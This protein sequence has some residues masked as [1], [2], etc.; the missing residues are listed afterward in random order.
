MRSPLQDLIAGAQVPKRDRTFI[1]RGDTFRA[2]GR[3]GNGNRPA[4]RHGPFIEPTAGRIPQ[5]HEAVRE[6]G[7]C[8]RPI[9][10]D[11]QTRDTPLWAVHRLGWFHPRRVQQRERERIG[12][13]DPAIVVVKR[14]ADARAFQLVPQSRFG[15]ADGP[16]TNRL[17]EAGGDEALTRFASRDRGHAPLVALE[18]HW[19]EFLG[20]VVWRRGVGK[21]F[22]VLWL[23][24]QGWSRLRS[25]PLGDALCRIRRDGLFFSQEAEIGPR[26]DQS[27]DHDADEQSRD[28]RH[29]AFLLR[30]PRDHRFRL[31]RFGLGPS[32]WRRWWRGT[33]AGF[34]QFAGRN[35]FRRRRG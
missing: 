29:A 3:N 7:E 6:A 22:I 9:R 16:D 32:S 8:A 21:D 25:S 23:V 30:R 18:D 1:D 11:G 17:I 14:Y 12:R 19:P 24:D 13:G 15:A 2:V 34:F 5:A 31:D 26:G 10:G 4:S 27:D 35:G 20:E 33:R 28:D